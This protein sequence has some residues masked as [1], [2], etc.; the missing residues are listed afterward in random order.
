MIDGVFKAIG[1][2]EKFRNSYMKRKP[3]VSKNGI[4]N[5]KGSATQNLQLV[6]LAKAGKLKK[7]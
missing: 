4:S 2:P 5:Y 3:I 1:V 6:K 7:I